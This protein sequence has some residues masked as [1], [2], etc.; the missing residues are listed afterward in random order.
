[1]SRLVTKRET[2]AALDLSPMGRPIFALLCSITLLLFHMPLLLGLSLPSFAS[3]RTIRCPWSAHIECKIISAWMQSKTKAMLFKQRLLRV[4][5]W[6]FP[7]LCL[8]NREIILHYRRRGNCQLAGDNVLEELKAPRSVR[9]IMEIWS[10]AGE[11]S[12]ANLHIGCYDNARSIAKHRTKREQFPNDME[13]V[14]LWN[15]SLTVCTL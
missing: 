3:Y 13:E 8:P 1:M 15:V 11:R 14:I 5:P 2:L 9:A 6:I 12:V 10:E 4:D 7:C